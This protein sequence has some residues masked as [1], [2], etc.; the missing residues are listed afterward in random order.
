MK[1]IK[2]IVLVLL[3]VFVGIQFIPTTLNQSNEILDSDFMQIYNVPK[4]IK[5]QIKISCYDCHSNNTHYPWYNR[6]QPITWLLEDHISKGKKELNFSEFGN[7]S[8]RKKKSKFKSIISQ[9]KDNE[10]PMDM[11]TLIHRNAIL[12]E[13]KKSEII[14]YMEG[15]RNQL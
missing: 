10:M 12:T 5:N 2:T 4:T 7:Y 9:I 8:K 1:I 13:L 11:Y 3:I 6:I 15:L 14:E